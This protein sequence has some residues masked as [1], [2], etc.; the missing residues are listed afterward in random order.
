MRPLRVFPGKFWTENF[1][2]CTLRLSNRLSHFS[3]RYFC[4][5]RIIKHVDYLTRN[6][7][8]FTQNTT[9]F[10]TNKISEG[11][12]TKQNSSMIDKNKI[13]HSI[14][15]DL[16]CNFSI[17]PHN[18]WAL[19][20]WFQ[21]SISLLHPGLN[22][23]IIACRPV[24]NFFKCSP[25]FLLISQIQEWNKFFPIWYYVCLFIQ[26]SIFMSPLEPMSHGTIAHWPRSPNL[27]RLHNTTNN[28][29]VKIDFR[30]EYRFRNM[31]RSPLFGSGSFISWVSIWTRTALKNK[32]SGYKNYSV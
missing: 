26:G 5:L 16:D 31:W 17:L 10:R 23:F 27:K 29:E 12:I 2:I 14:S 4:I 13:S 9:D 22:W 6:K 7:Q 25:L 8:Q 1:E 19:A 28:R 20:D 18:P 3:W 32:P 24:L 11:L 15:E 21:W 30:Y